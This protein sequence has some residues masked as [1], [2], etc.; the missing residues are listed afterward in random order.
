MLTLAY[1][2][3][4]ASFIAHVNN[5]PK[6]WRH[7]PARCYSEN[8]TESFLTTPIFYVNAGNVIYSGGTHV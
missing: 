1:R 7:L 2:T 3:K 8:K 6:V 5:L 4:L